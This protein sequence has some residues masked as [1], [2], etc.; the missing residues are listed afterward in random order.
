[1]LNEYTSIDLAS[2]K[3]KLTPAGRRYLKAIYMQLW[4]D[5]GEGFNRATG[6]GE[7]CDVWF[8]AVGLFRDY[9]DKG[10]EG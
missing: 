4:H 5:S 7:V 3:V 1:M 6:L 8:E 2:G 10:E 9:V